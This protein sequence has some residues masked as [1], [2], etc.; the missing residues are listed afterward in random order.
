MFN[1]EN[2]QD[3]AVVG[4]GT[5]D[6]MGYV[7]WVAVLEGKLQHGRPNLLQLTSGR[8]VTLAGITLRNSPQFHVHW[9]DLM[10]A[11]IYSVHV[12]V[13]VVG[14]RALLDKYGALHPEIPIPIFPLNTDGLD[15][16]G[17]NIHI[18]DCVVENFDDSVCIKACNMGNNLSKC[19]ENILVERIEQRL[20]VGMSIGSVG[21]STQISCV[22]NVTFRDITFQAPIKAIYIKTDPGTDGSGIIE[23]ITYENCVVH[24]PVWWA[25]Y[26]GPQQMKEPDHSG[27]GCMFYPVGPCETQPLITIRSVTLRN[28]TVNNGL[29]FPGIL[30]CNASNPCEDFVFDDVVVSDWDIG[31]SEGFICEYVNGTARN[32][33]PSPQCLTQV[34]AQPPKPG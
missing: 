31:K 14:Q 16:T 9:G 34:S 26:I 8:N 17:S 28:V 6:G 29:L 15:V 25:I 7:W 21:P 12:L 3:F 11:E 1:F 10:G 23:N 19:S 33:R 4:N 22:R 5:I 27:P 13:D 32:S 24:D 30:R 18:H 20:G 2:C